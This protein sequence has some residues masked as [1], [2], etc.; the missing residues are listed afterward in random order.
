MHSTSPLPDGEVCVASHPHNS[1]VQ[2]YNRFVSEIER[3]ATEFKDYLPFFAAGVA[4]L[5]GFG[6][7]VEYVANIRLRAGSIPIPKETALAAGLSFA[8]F[9][10]PFLAL[11]ASLWRN[12]FVLR[13]LNYLALAGILATVVCLMSSLGTMNPTTSTLL[14]FGIAAVGPIVTAI[15]FVAV[16]NGF[17]TLR[18]SARI[19]VLATCLYGHCLSYGTLVLPRM[20]PALGGFILRPVRLALTSGGLF[21]ALLGVNGDDFVLISKVRDEDRFV[22]S[23]GP[24]GSRPLVTRIGFGQIVSLESIATADYQKT[25]D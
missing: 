18:A 23:F 9:S 25:F 22:D 4:L 21:D 19:C 6:W 20:H 15:L 12:E 13:K 2:K 7:F 3:K 17:R 8:A 10:V 16:A 5:Y 1:L 24:F 11:V 14:R